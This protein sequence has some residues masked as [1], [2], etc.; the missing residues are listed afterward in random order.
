MHGSLNPDAPSWRLASFKLLVM[1][2]LI[3]RTLEITTSVMSAIKSENST[4]LDPLSFVGIELA[5]FTRM[6]GGV[7]VW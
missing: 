6:L 5:S 7:G 4:R 2:L 3:E 1:L